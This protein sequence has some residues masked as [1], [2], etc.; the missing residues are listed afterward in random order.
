MD[1]LDI[2]DVC[3][4]YNSFQTVK[5]LE[6]WVPFT[7]SHRAIGSGA[8]VAED[9]GSQLPHVLDNTEDPE[10]RENEGGSGEELQSVAPGAA[11]ALWFCLYCTFCSWY[12]PGCQVQVV[13]D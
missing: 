12:C 6:E 9:A 2:T 11:T 7:N 5:G 8:G 1:A 4:Y 10:P 13:T 3:V